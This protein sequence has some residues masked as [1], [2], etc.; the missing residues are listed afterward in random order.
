MFGKHQ[1]GENF[2]G[3]GLKRLLSLRRVDAAQPDRNKSFAAIQQV[4]RVA[5]NDFDDA[6]IQFLCL[7]ESTGSSKPQRQQGEWQV[8]RTLILDLEQERVILS[9]GPCWL[10]C[11]ALPVGL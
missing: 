11:V 1:V 10:R 9:Q 2:L 3:N 6:T 4:H 5:V 8:A 7:G